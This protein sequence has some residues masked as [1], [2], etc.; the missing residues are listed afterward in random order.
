[1]SGDDRA[2]V[3]SISDDDVQ[4]NYNSDQNLQQQQQKHPCNN[5]N[6]ENDQEYPA[7][8]SGDNETE[9][10]L[11][12]S[13]VQIANLVALSAKKKSDLSVF[14]TLLLAFQ[15][16]LFIGL[17]GLI[18]V[19]T[20]Q[21]YY[22]GAG[23]ATTQLI[24][25]FLAAA[26]FPLGI[27]LVVVAGSE[28]FTGNVA[29][30]FCGWMARRCSLGDLVRNWSLALSGNLLGSL[31]CAFFFFLHSE[32]LG[33]EGETAL[34]NLVEHKAGGTSGSFMVRAIACNVLVCLAVWMAYSARD[35]T[36]KIV[37]MWLPI[38]TFVYLGFEHGVA[39]M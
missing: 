7:S 10:S 27:V 4:K 14:Q 11:I 6:I 23:D 19:A 33:P 39:D 29:T 31:F 1:M 12:A 8:K 17:G 36:G 21:A 25:Q 34:I 38:F 20:G 15:A 2:E 5:A 37:S 26:T 16:G 24:S 9:V 22:T 13:P 18:A 3:R 35:T 32:S 30:M 28:L